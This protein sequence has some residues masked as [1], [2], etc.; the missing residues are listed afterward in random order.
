[1]IGLMTCLLH[2]PFDIWTDRSASVKRKLTLLSAFLVESFPCCI[3]IRTQ[4]DFSRMVLGVPT[5]VLSGCEVGH[6][7]VLVLL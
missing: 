7:I 6:Q 5:R 1:M 4:K 3:T 2:C